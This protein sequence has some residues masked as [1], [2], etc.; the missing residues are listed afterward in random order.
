MET[1]VVQQLVTRLGLRPEQARGAVGLL[2][3]LAQEHLGTQEFARLAQYI[4]GSNDLIAAAPPAGGLSSAFGGLTSVFGGQ[5]AAVGA[6][7]NAVSGFAQL[8]LGGE[9][10]TETLTVIRTY[11]ESKGGKAAAEQLSQMLQ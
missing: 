8:G 10:V 9:Q 5:A 11:L 7:A 4:P 2:L 6:L 3:K 1:E